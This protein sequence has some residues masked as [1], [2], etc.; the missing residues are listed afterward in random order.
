MPTYRLTA[1]NAAGHGYTY[2]WGDAYEVE[3]ATYRAA[4]EDVLGRVGTDGEKAYAR[5]VRAWLLKDG[6][7][8]A[9]FPECEDCH[10]AV[11]ETEW[12]GNGR[13]ICWNCL[14]VRQGRTP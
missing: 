9:Q 2:G 8:W 11:A 14:D 7:N 6:W 3:A 4:E 12:A 5:I 13:M 1:V 10:N